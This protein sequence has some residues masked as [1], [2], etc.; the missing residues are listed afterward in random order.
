MK[1][2]KNEFILKTMFV[3]SNMNYTFDEKYIL[4]WIQKIGVFRICIFQT[5]FINKF[6]K[7]ILQK[8]I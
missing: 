8:M 3:Y 6:L 5:M 1:K 7:M 2:L 4:P